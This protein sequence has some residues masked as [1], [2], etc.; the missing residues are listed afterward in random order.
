[1]EN[2]IIKVSMFKNYRCLEM[3]E[4]VSGESQYPGFL[5]RSM[6][7]GFQLKQSLRTKNMY[8]FTDLLAGLFH[9]YRF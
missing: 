3:Y 4:M 8:I 1:M 6:A 7:G 5:P 2:K 9:I